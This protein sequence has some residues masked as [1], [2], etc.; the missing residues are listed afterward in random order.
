MLGDVIVVVAMRV[1]PPG[2]I[3]MLSLGRMMIC[4]QG[5]A[6]VA[7][8]CAAAG[9]YISTGAILKTALGASGEELG[10]ANMPSITGVLA[11]RMGAE[12]VLGRKIELWSTAVA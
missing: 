9:A 10:E 2:T 12:V 6:G 5:I 3:A 11:P 8:G 1:D 4:G 7:V